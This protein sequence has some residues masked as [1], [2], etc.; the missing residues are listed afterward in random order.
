MVPFKSK[1]GVS[2]IITQI[3]VSTA[4]TKKEEIAE[5]VKA[6]VG[7]DTR[8]GSERR[9]G[10]RI[11]K[12]DKK[13]A[14]NLEEIKPCYDAPV[15]QLLY[16]K[17]NGKNKRKK[18]PTKPTLYFVHADPNTEKPANPPVNSNYRPRGS[19]LPNHLIM[20]Y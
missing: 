20:M 11:S 19:A 8:T 18:T 17:G 3:H 16:A 5:D 15:Y 10:N 4:I 9:L 6:P 7:E 12:K 14:E 13:I 2:S 1:T